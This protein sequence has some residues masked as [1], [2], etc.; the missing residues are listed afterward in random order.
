MPLIIN[1]IRIVTQ[2]GQN[3]GAAGARPAKADGRDRER[4]I[5]EITE[6]ILRTLKEKEER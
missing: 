5:A 4:L 2:V 6:Q 1:E 3:E